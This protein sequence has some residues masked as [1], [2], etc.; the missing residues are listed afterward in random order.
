[1]P[2]PRNSRAAPDEVALG[3]IVGVFGIR[4]EVRVHL[5]N[6]ESDLLRDGREVVLIGPDGRR[7]R[8]TLRTRSGAGGRV[9]GRLEGVQDRDAARAWM[10]WEIVL[11]AEEL[12]DP[13]P[14]TWYVR[15]LLGLEVQDE[16]GSRLGRLV[17][18]HA[19]GPVDV[20]EIEGDDGPW[21]LPALKERIVAVDLQARRVVV[22]GGRP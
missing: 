1:M 14:D 17:E 18:V 16:Q 12:P 11:P 21:F 7:V 15:D 13:G 22:R 3:W 4:G 10:G 5:H 20:W 8:R 19:T 9:L 2:P 6:R